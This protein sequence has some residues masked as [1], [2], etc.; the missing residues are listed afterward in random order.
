MA[1]AKTEEPKETK[2]ETEETKTETKKVEETKTETKK[3]EE[4]KKEV[5]KDVRRIFL[6]NRL[7]AINRIHDEGKAKRAADALFRK[8]N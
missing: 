4:T 1:K 5:K 8:G 7:E 6:E 2:K 3:V